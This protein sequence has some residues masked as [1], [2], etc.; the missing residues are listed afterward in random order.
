MDLYDELPQS[1]LLCDEEFT[2]LLDACKKYQVSVVD[3]LTLPSKELARQLQRSTNE[4]DKF[5]KSMIAEYDDQLMNFNE[6][7]PISEVEGPVPFTTTDVGIDEALGGGIYTHGITEVFGES[8][9]GKS[10][11]LMQ[12]CLSVQLPTN[13]GGIKGKCVYISTEGDLPTQRLASMISAREELVKHGV[14]QENVY[15]VTCCDLINQDHILNVQLPILLENSRGAIKLI[16][17]DSISH[18]MRVE[19]PTRDFKDHQD[20]RFYVDQV[21]E[22]LLDLANKHALAVVVAN[23]V[24]DRPLFESPEPYVAELTDYE[25]QLGWWVGWRNSSIIYHQKYNEP[26][27]VNSDYQDNEDLLSDDEDGKLI[28]D[29]IARVENLSR[30][31]AAKVTVANSEKA[32]PPDKRPIERRS[33]F[34]SNKQRFHKK[35]S[36]D[37]RVPNLGLNWAKHLSSRILLSKSYRASPMI[38]RGELHL[39]KGSDPTTFWQVKRL[40]KVVFSAYADSKEIPFMITKRGLESSLGDD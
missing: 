26:K 40:F 18:H 21:A 27:N 31:K 36:V 6:V 16:I 25:Y 38:R 19:L 23:Q 11:L 30:T 15:T 22:R 3:F 9:T 5:Q 2:S 37:R 34:P 33:T 14:S 35:R 4:V 28:H 24:S 7:K 29:E 1:S 13:M 8:S 20:N 32:L 10:Q 12:L 39:Y 17:I